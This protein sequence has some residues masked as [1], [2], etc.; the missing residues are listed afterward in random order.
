MER[1]KLSKMEKKVMGHLCKYDKEAL[2][3]FSRFSVEK[4]CI[5]LNG[6]GL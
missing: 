3:D 6:K 2:D 4:L 5:R 1:I